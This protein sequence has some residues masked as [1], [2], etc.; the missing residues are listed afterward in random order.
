MVSPKPSSSIFFLNF[1]SA[2][3]NSSKPLVIFLY[4]PESSQN[5]NYFSLQIYSCTYIYEPRKFGTF[6]SICLA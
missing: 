5:G 3:V 4:H 6:E 2:Y 1:F